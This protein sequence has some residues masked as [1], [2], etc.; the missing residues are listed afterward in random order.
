MNLNVNRAARWAKAH[1]QQYDG[2]K[3]DSPTMQRLRRGGYGA[4]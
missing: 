3:D 4:R 2:G 1:E